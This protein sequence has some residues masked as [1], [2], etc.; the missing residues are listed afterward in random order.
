MFFHTFKMFV[1]RFVHLDL[2]GKCNFN[3][4]HCRG[5]VNAKH[6]DK[7]ELFAILE[8]IFTLW[9]ENI[10]W[11]ELG[12]GETLLYPYLLDVVKKI[13]QESKAKVLIVSNGYFFSKERGFDLKKAGLDRIQFSLDGVDEE[14][15]NW[16]RQNKESYAKVV[17]AT[18]ICRE[19][20]L[21]FVLRA[22]LNERNKNQ[23]EDYF[24]LAKNLGASEIGMRGCI[25]VGNAKDNEKD[26]FL[27][28]LEY[29]EILKKLPKISK[30]YEIPYFSGDPLALVA[31][32]EMLSKI[33]DKYGS[34]DVYAGCCV[35]ISYL[36]INSDGKVS[37]CPMLNEVVIGDPKEKDILDIWNESEEF[38]K[39]RNRDM[40]G[41]CKTC[42]YLKLCGGCCAY[43]YW[44]SGKLF[45]ENP[46]C[47]FHE[48]KMEEN[49]NG[50][51]SKCGKK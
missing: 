47:T 36:H 42:K 18:K 4:L 46:I 38:L 9:K 35:G 44:K 33:E 49:K 34:L 12:G 51:S 10:E 3:C 30:K 41:K 2:T 40:G 8:R 27:D 13:K 31:N 16:L 45:S 7:N 28:K 50:K 23:I 5:R 15:H 11:I 19:L 24:K 32:K 37:F 14:T 21:P 43:G 17:Q 48:L 26:L 20:S 29:A 22:T 25:Y 6:L 39:M 1:P